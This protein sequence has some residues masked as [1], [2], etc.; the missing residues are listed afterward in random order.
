VKGEDAEQIIDRAG[1]QGNVLERSVAD[2]NVA[3]WLE[4]A[5]RQFRMF[6]AGSMP[7]NWTPDW[8]GELIAPVLSQF[9]SQH[10]E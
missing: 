1:F 10:R 5:K 2:L 7:T 6:S 4:P 8:L 9:H 3:K